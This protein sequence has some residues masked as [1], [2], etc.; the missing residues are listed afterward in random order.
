MAAGGVMT[1]RFTFRAGRIRFSAPVI[2]GKE[3]ESMSNRTV[4]YTASEIGRVRVV[5]DVLPALAD[6]V[7]R[8]DNVKVTLCLSPRSLDFFKREAR[9]RGVS[10]RRMI[11]TLVDTYAERRAGRNPG[12]GKA[13]MPPAVKDRRTAYDEVAGYR[14]IPIPLQ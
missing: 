10:Y 12:S 13:R 9:K 4:R 1:V 11:R 5:A 2:D 6:V 7:P 14:I 3:S 8:E